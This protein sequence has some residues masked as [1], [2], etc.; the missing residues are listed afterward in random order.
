MD[1]KKLIELLN[2]DEYLYY[3]YM[4]GGIDLLI[5]TIENRFRNEPTLKNQ[6]LEKDILNLIEGV[7][8]V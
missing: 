8:N 2:N 3:I 6:S 4:R 1:R 7:N 5:E